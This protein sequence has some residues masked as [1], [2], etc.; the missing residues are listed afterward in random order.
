MIPLQRSG[1][2]RSQTRAQRFSDAVFRRRYWVLI[3]CAFLTLL[4]GAGVLK[5][6]L[7]SNYEVYFDA[8]NPRLRALNEFHQTF[9]RNDNILF[10]LAPDDNQVFTPATLAAIS[11]LTRAGWQLPYAA[12]VDSVSNFQRIRSSPEG[13]VIESLLADDGVVSAAQARELEQLAL[14]EP[15]LV[16]RLLSPGANVTGINVRLQITG[17]TRLAVSRAAEAAAEL[18]VRMRRQY[19]RIAVYLT[20]NA[21]LNAAFPEAGMYDLTHLTPFMY[22]MIFVSMLVLLRSVPASLAAFSVVLMASITA[23]GLAGW[24][25]LVLSSASVVAP[26]IISTVA[27]A[28]GVHLLT[29][30]LRE[31]RQGH[32][33]AAAFARSLR[34]NFKPVAL[35]TLTTAVGFLSLNFSDAPPFRDL[36]NITATGVLAALFF[37]LLV[38]PALLFV[39]PGSPARGAAGGPSLLRID[40]YAEW[41]IRRHRGAFWIT[42]VVVAL[43]SSAIG[44][45]QLNDAFVEYFDQRVAFRRDTDFTMENLTGIY[46]L[47]YALNAGVEDGVF[48]PDYLRQLE[49]FGNW[50]KKQPE[51]MHVTTLTEVL[52]RL[53]QHVGGGGYALP[54]TRQLAAQYLLLYEISIPYGL[55]LNARLSVDRSTSRVTVTL[56][57]LDNLQLRNLESRAAAWLKANTAA[58]LWAPALGASIMFAYIAES[59]IKATLEG[60]LVAIVII[61]LILMVVFRSFPIAILSL[62]PNV[63]PALTAF[64]LWALLVGQM[65]VALVIV[66]A[67]SLGIVVDDTIHLVANFVHARRR[68]QKNAEDA[69]RYAFAVAG[70]ALVSTSVILV[71]GFSVLTLSS[72]QVNHG[73]G[74]LTM[75]VIACALVADFLMLPGILIYAGRRGWM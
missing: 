62:L 1:L 69:V 43:L 32:D 67:M 26:T 20:G 35:T 37:T 8:E 38:L 68:L 56:R 49:A 53:N 63:V 19:P 34:I 16:G 31:L 36:G 23:M 14:A 33:R 66:A 7:A 73:M 39:L 45:V 47:E 65:G 27:I 50:L 54:E 6:R 10:V 3:G 41:I 29:G 9:S 70:S 2:P 51:V 5:L 28:D 30:Y 12:R 25:S 60:A 64:G 48:D 24:S 17:D 46:Q 13:V 18:A 44:R 22:L 75:L 74:Q 4:A 59:N 15:A 72:F 21:M 57:N 55:D 52:K 61:A 40:R 58:N 71:L 11:E 42:L